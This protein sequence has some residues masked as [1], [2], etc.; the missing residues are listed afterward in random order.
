MIDEGGVA[1]ARDSPADVA[2]LSRARD[3]LWICSCPV[4][5]LTH[6]LPNVISKSFH[7]QNGPTKRDSVLELSDDHIFWEL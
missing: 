7:L 6:K 1:R 3:L 4:N 5:N 2:P